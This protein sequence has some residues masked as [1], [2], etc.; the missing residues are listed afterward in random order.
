MMFCE[1][2]WAAVPHA[3]GE[4]QGPK[5]PG[6]TFV[7][8]S[9]PKSAMGLLYFLDAGPQ[10]SLARGSPLCCTGMQATQAEL[11]WLHSA[12]RVP[13]LRHTTDIAVLCG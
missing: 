6:V 1:G 12:F 7:L 13:G 5:R 2:T 8:S 4:G 3:G 11:Y 9:A 10:I